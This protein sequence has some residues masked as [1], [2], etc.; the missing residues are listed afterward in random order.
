MEE[1]LDPRRRI[2]SKVPRG[3]GRCRML[4]NKKAGLEKPTEKSKRMVQQCFAQLENKDWY[5]YEI[6]LCL[7]SQKKTFR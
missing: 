3:T 6:Y 5:K 1:A 7:L 4:P 2:P